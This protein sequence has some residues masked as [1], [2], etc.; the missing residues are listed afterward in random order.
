MLELKSSPIAEY[1]IHYL[2]R[3]SIHAPVGTLSFVQA[4]QAQHIAMYSFSSINAMQGT[5]LSLEPEA[6]FERLIALRQGGYCFEHNRVMF[7]ALEALGYSVRPALAR[8]MLS[9]KSDNPRTHRV[10]LL[11]Y[12]DHTYVVDVGFGVKVPIMPIAIDHDHV[13]NEGPNQYRVECTDSH[14]KVSL[15]EPESLTLYEIDLAKVFEED[16]E[17]GHF[18]SHQHPEAAFVNNLVVSRVDD[19][20]RYL[21]RNTT[22][23]CLDEREQT[24]SEL[25]IRSV[26]Q[27]QQLLQRHFNIVVTKECLNKVFAKVQVRQLARVG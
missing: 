4:L 13:A 23:L 27:L 15:L 18:Y 14:V 5:Y 1:I 19:G 12:N 25:E 10:T 7:L 16:C 3:F 26:S 24:Q 11:T 2:S 8:V 17:V 9:G 22:F 6:L 20:K 21:I